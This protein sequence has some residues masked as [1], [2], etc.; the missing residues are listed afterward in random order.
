[1]H[2]RL[3]DVSKRRARLAEHTRQD[4][5]EPQPSR[6][7]SARSASSTASDGD[8]RGMAGGRCRGVAQPGEEEPANG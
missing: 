4:G 7:E 5:R 6:C 1:V 8:P 3:R 2:L